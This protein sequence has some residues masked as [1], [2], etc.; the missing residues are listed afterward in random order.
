MPILRA[1]SGAERPCRRLPRPCIRRTRERIKATQRPIQ[2]I[3]H[4]EPGVDP[5]PLGGCRNGKRSRANSWHRASRT[6]GGFGARTKAAQIVM[7]TPLVATDVQR[8][9]GASHT[10]A[11]SSRPAVTHHRSTALHFRPASPPA[12]RSDLTVKVA[13]KRP[14]RRGAV[15]T[16]AAVGDGFNVRRAAGEGWRGPVLR[17][18]A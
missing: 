17:A 1:L 9:T 3:Q 10:R 5:T 11:A 12:K 15:R 18:G 14:G 4:A 8:M 7:I 16:F 2:D 13:R 6:T